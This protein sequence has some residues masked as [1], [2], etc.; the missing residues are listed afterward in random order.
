M[1]LGNRLDP[2]VGG[3]ASETDVEDG[4]VAFEESVGLRRGQLSS[5]EKPLKSDKDGKE[6]GV[7]KSY[8]A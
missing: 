1:S 6:E 3:G 2:C 8:T 7:L 4:G 5:S